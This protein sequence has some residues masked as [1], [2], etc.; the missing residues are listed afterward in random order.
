MNLYFVIEVIKSQLRRPWARQRRQIRTTAGRFAG[1]ASRKTSLYGARHVLV[2]AGRRVQRDQG[3]AAAPAPSLRRV[4][5]VCSGSVARPGKQGRW[6]CCLLPPPLSIAQPS[7]H[8]PDAPP[9]VG[10]NQLTYREAQLMQTSVGCLG[11]FMRGGLKEGWAWCVPY[12]QDA[13]T[14]EGQGAVC[15][16]SH[17]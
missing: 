16:R 5:A 11:K 14:G 8:L 9:S 13:R 4:C 2:D 12:T 3:A 7:D 10:R 17:T 15:P 1:V 6:R